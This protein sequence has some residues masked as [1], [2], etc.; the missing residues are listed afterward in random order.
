EV[1][2]SGLGEPR[3]RLA[4]RVFHDDKRARAVVQHVGQTPAADFYVAAD[5]IIA[6]VELDAHAGFGGKAFPAARP[7]HTLRS[8][9][10]PRALQANEVAIAR[11]LQQLVREHAWGL[12]ILGDVDQLIDEV[13]RMAEAR[14]EPAPI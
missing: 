10:V 4:H 13:A 3:Q 14:L 1:G 12:H 9:L 8:W 11:G 2:A 5:V 7:Q 6:G